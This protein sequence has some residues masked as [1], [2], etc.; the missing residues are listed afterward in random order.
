MI[1][2]NASN[3][4]I[5]TLT[6]IKIS[7]GKYTF[8]ISCCW[9]SIAPPP[10]PTAWL[11]KFQIIKPEKAKS[12]YGQNR[13]GICTTLSK[14]KVNKTTT[15]KG[16]SISHRRFNLVCTYCTFRSWIVKI[17]SRFLYLLEN[18]RAHIGRTLWRFH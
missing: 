14:I 2:T 4:A 17:Q 16:L 15:I 13:S 8:L 3:S 10:E 5:N 18:L 12:G 11:K 6:R 7:L 1:E 9:L